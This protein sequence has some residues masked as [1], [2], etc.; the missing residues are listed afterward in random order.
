MTNVLNSSI[1]YY[2]KKVRFID[3]HFP[4]LPYHEGV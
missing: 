4:F 1:I 2:N 3:F